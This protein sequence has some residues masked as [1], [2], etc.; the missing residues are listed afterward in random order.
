MQYLKWMPKI[1]Y[2]SIDAESSI[3]CDPSI[4][5]GAVLDLSLGK[6]ES[7][8]CAQTTHIGAKVYN[9]AN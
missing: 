7:C 5:S 9:T 4:T 2:R 6:C 8:G 3:L 1:A